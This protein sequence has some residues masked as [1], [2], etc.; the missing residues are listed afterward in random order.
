MPF[1]LSDEEFERRRQ[2]SRARAEQLAKLHAERA[3]ETPEEREERFRRQWAADAKAEEDRKRRY[4]R[5]IE[6]KADR[7]LRDRL[8]LLPALTKL[9]P[10][11]QREDL[12]RA[13]VWHRAYKQPE[14]TRAAE[15]AKDPAI[16]AKYVKDEPLDVK[17]LAFL[18]QLLMDGWTWT[19]VV[20]GFMKPMDAK[21]A[22]ARTAKL[23]SLYNVRVTDVR[24]RMEYNGINFEF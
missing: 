5:G 15:Q 12:I 20:T 21:L 24:A 23:C 3:K 10:T 13:L 1:P 8:R 17:D 4:A 22:L 2:E 19:T 18:A 7:I 14:W 16:Q 9:L 11:C 6:E